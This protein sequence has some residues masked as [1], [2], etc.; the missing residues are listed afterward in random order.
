MNGAYAGAVSLSADCIGCSGRQVSSSV[1]AIITKHYSL[2]NLKMTNLSPQF[3]RLG[4]LQTVWSG[5]SFQLRGRSLLSSHSRKG[6]GHFGTSFIRALIP[7]MEALHVGPNY[8]S[9]SLPCNIIYSMLGQHT[10]LGV[11]GKIFRP[12]H[13]SLKVLTYTL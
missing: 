4:S 11:D 1:W 10:N 2:G 12:W 7:F 9:K 8:I 6:E 3:C 5:S 13:S